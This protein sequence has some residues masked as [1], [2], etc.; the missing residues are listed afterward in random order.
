MKAVRRDEERT[1]AGGDDDRGR[2]PRTRRR[3]HWRRGRL[4]ADGSYVRLE[5]NTSQL[6]RN[7]AAGRPTPADVAAIAFLMLF[8][9][10][11]SPVPYDQLL[12]GRTCE[13][14]PFEKYVSHADGV[15]RAGFAATGAGRRGNVFA[16]RCRPTARRRPAVVERELRCRFRGRP[17]DAVVTRVRA[18][19]GREPQEQEQVRRHRT[20]GGHVRALTLRAAGENWRDGRRG[21]WMVIARGLRPLCAAQ[22]FYSARRPDVER[23]DNRSGRSAIFPRAHG[24]RR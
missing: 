6:P 1:C 23:F 14:R 17:D 13:A 16:V 10:L 11:A 19:R 9:A 15:A 20:G 7:S 2:C 22:S 12:V 5:V 18:H 8:V 3:R 4:D 24:R 21:V